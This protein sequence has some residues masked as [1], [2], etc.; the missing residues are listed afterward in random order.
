MR[1]GACRPARITQKNLR[2]LLRLFLNYIVA[3]NV[4]EFGHGAKLTLIVPARAKRAPRRDI[5]RPDIT[6]I[7]AH[8]EASVLEGRCHRDRR[9]GAARTIHQVDGLVRGAPRTRN[10]FK[11]YRQRKAVL[12]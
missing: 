5:A 12:K 9:A 1:A 6:R 2:L 10:V 3:E 8:E 7:A 11:T 4:A